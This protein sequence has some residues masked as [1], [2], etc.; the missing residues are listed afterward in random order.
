M[1][2]GLCPLSRTTWI[3]AFAYPTDGKT[4]PVPEAVEEQMKTL[5]N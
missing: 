5:I 4:F 2:T 1:E 3:A